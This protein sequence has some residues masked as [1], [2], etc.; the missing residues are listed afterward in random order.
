[1]SPQLETSK[2]NVKTL[3]SI[4]GKA[5]LKATNYLLKQYKRNNF[6]STILRLYL[7]YGPRQDF[8][9][10]VPLIIKGCLSNS[11]FPCSSGIQYRDFLYVDDFVNLIFACL[12]NKKSVGEVF[13]IGSGKPQKIKK[14]ILKIQKSI[15]LGKPEFGKVKFRKDEILKLYPSIQ[16]AKQLIGWY[17]KVRFDQGIINTINF[18]KKDL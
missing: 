18:Y 8:N 16:K 13:N 5:K 4:Y 11:L 6:P 14:I 15:K 10:F 2:T 7:V 3:K 9:R 12:K 17:P 1:M